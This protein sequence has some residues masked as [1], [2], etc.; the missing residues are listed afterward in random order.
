VSAADLYHAGQLARAIEAQTQAV[1]KQP[2]DPGLR[3]FL[4]ELL[5]FAGDF[6]RAAKQLQAVTFDD[7]KKQHALGLYQHLL[8][9]ERKRRPVFQG[10]ATPQ[11]FAPPPAHVALRLQS[12]VQA[13]ANNAAAAAEAIR[14]AEEITR[15][16]PGN[17]NGTAYQSLADA[18]QVLGPVL[19]VMA[20]GE[21]FWAPLEQIATLTI[22]APKYPRD[23]LWASAHLTMRH[24]QEGD[25]FLPVLYPGSPEHADDAVKL[26]RMTDWRQEGDGPARGNGAKMLF[27]DDTDLL[28]LDCREL[29][30]AEPAPAAASAGSA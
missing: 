28:L 13:R 7:A 29:V 24:G 17:V 23:L 11:F 22:T 19:E 18:D 26:G 16:V 8:E 14:H 2:G 1:R 25:V 3:I 4:F 12:L 9:A 15:A 27:T 30:L 6:E 20:H 21:Y 10:E 5:A